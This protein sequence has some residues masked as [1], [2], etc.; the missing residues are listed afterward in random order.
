MEW[1]E[2]GS[3]NSLFNNLQK[4]VELTFALARLRGGYPK[5]IL[6]R[7]IDNTRRIEINISICNNDIL[8]FETWLLQS[9]LIKVDG[10]TPN[11]KESP[12]IIFLQHEV[13]VQ[14]FAFKK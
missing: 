14:R 13:I 7:V 12:L 3:M 4:E 5:F 9:S 2:G 6:D 10:V 1:G 11:V 8:K